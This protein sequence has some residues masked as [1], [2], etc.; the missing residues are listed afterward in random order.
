M[1]TWRI[2]HDFIDYHILVPCRVVDAPLRI[3]GH[4]KPLAATVGKGLH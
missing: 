4:G 1:I 2:K 3:L